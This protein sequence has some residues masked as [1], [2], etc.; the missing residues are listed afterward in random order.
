MSEPHLVTNSAILEKTGLIHRVRHPESPGPH[1]TVVLLHGYAG[2][3]D[4]MWIFART[5]PAD[6]LLVAPRAIEEDSQG[7]NYSWYPSHTR[8]W[9]SL[10]DFDDAVAAV[11]R[12]IVA[13]PE[14]YQADPDRIYLMGFSQGA[15]T[16]Y[17]TALQRPRLVRAIAGLVGF[18]PEDIPPASARA[19]FEGMPIFMAVGEEDETIP[20]DYAR[21]GATLL[22][23]AG[24]DLTYHELSTGHKLNSAGMRALKQW[25]AERD[26]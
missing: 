14:V 10:D 11:T 20:V 5:I 15:A 19:A 22:R 24:A 13:L 2:N 1:P 16:A 21:Q 7:G 18:V 4:V 6:W 9:P 3:E 8:R 26:G 23:Q 12:F 17:V 25:W